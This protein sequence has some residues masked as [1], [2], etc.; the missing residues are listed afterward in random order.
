V[1]VHIK[2]GRFMRRLMDHMLIPDLLEQ[3]LWHDGERLPED[4]YPES[5]ALRNSAAAP[6]S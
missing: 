4:A 3:R 2:Q 5:K 6:S 1:E